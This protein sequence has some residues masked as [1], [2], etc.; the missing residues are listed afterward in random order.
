MENICNI[1]DEPNNV[2]VIY[3]APIK[4]KGKYKNIQIMKK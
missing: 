1:H 4:L 2:S 3:L